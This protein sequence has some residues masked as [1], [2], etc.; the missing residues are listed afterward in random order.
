MAARA[1]PEHDI[2]V[3][4][5]GRLRGSFDAV[6]VAVPNGGRRGK[7][8][9][10]DLRA[11][12]VESGHP[13]LIAYGRDGRLLLMEVKAPGGSLSAEQRRL[14]PKLRDRGFPVVVVRDVDGAVRAMREAGFGP[15]V[16][17]AAEPT[18]GF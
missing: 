7:R 4:I 1:R 3:A 10:V 6:V 16:P 12:G 8:E 18:T 5:V 2:Q 17:P 15:R 9:A 13:D 14:I 11:E